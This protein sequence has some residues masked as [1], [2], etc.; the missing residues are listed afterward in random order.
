MKK[1]WI[2]DFNNYYGSGSVRE[3]EF[4]K[5]CPFIKKDG[6]NS[7]LYENEELGLR[8]CLYKNKADAEYV[9]MM[10]EQD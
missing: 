7:Y 5:D 8:R 4:P 1:Y 2:V 10:L 6:K 9:L 3:L